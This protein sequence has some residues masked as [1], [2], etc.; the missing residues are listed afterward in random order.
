[1]RRAI[2]HAEAMFFVFAAHDLKLGI[3][4]T[5][6]AAPPHSEEDSSK[7]YGVRSSDFTEKS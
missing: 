4:A 6:E 7:R 3:T 2:T 1:M 5:V